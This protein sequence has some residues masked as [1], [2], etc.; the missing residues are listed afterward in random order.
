MPMTEPPTPAP[1]E[2]ADVAIADAI[3]AAP[4]TWQA[5]IPDYVKIGDRWIADVTVFKQGDS[6]AVTVTHNGDDAQVVS[7]INAAIAQ[8]DATAQAPTLIGV[9]DLTPAA[10]REPEPPTQLQ[11]D[12][13]AFYAAASREFAQQRFASLSPATQKLCTDPSWINGMPRL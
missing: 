12:Q 1:V 13:Q 6:F 9:V 11:L 3:K 5:F 2:D 10:V 7:Q 4:D 8:R